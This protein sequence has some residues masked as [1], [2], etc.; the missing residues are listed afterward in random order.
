[1]PT[2][3]IKA[4][5]LIGI[6]CALLL[7]FS[8]SCHKKDRIDRI[9]IDF[10]KQEEADKVSGNSD[11]PLTAA[12]SAM[13]SPRENF[14]YYSRIFDYVSEKMGRK[15]TY[16]QKRTYAEVNELIRRQELDFAFICSGAYVEARKDFGAQILVVPQI[17]GATVYYGYVIVNKNSNLAN[18]SDLKGHSF[19]FTDPLSNTG[20]IYPTYLVGYLGDPNN[21]FFS[22]VIFT[23]AHDYSIQAV[24]SGLVDAACVSSLIFDYIQ[25]IHPEKTS[26]VRIIHKSMPFGMPPLVVHPRIDPDLKRKLRSILLEMDV[27]PKGK[28]ILSRLDIERFVEKDER[29]YGFINSMRNSIQGKK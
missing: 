21:Q 26:N 27:D 23:H 29:D 5:F 7:P 6:P 1:M 13:I 20:F 2:K 16:K 11:Q 18:F 15:I 10:S 12:V 3:S 4:I 8:G 14:S 9:R 19:A 22:H 25:R 17:E 24:A 28:D